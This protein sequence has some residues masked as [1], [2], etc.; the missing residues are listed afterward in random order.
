MLIDGVTLLEGSNI[1]NAV[2][3]N[4]PIFPVGPTHSP[5]LGE[6]FFKTDNLDGLGA[7]GLYVYDGSTWTHIVDGTALADATSVATTINSGTLFPSDHVIVNGE[8]FFL[9]STYND[10]LNSIVYLPGLYV[11]NIAAGI[12]G[13]WEIIPSAVDQMDAS[14]ITSGTMN[15]ARVPDLSWTK[16]TTDKPT[17]I[18]GYG[19]TDAVSSSSLTTH[20]NDETKHL[21][22]AQNALI[23]EIS[24]SATEINYLS[25]TTENIH[26]ALVGKLSLTGG[27]MTGSIIL[28]TNTHISIAD[29]PTIGTHAANKNYVDSYVAGLTWKP[30]VKVATLT[31]IVLSSSQIIDGITLLTNDRVLVKNQTNLTENGIYTVAAGVWSRSLDM[32]ATTPINELN[33]AAVFVEQ[34]STQADTGWTQINQVS[35]LGSDPIAFTQ[36]NGAAGITTGVGLAK[37]GNTL[38]VLLG[39]GITELP[40]GDVGV[41]VLTSGGLFLTID[42]TTSSTLTDAQLSLTKVGTAGIY[43]SVTVDAHGRVTTGTNPTTLAGYSI[44]D[45]QGL[46]AVLTSIT[47]Q[48]SGT[49]LLKLT[50]GTASLDTT[51]YLTAN[52]AITL[53]GDVTGTGN[54]SFA[55]TLA[56]VTQGVGTNFV[57]INVDA[58]GRVIGNTAVAQSDI[59]SLLSTGSITNTM[60]V[61][62]AVANLSG[63][64]T[65][66]ETTASVRTLL[67]ITTLSGSNTG[68]QTITLTGGVTGSGTGSFIATVVTNANLTGDVTSIGN[69]TTLS[70]TTVTGKLLTGYT[71]TAG[72]IAAT[73]S[74]L[75]SINKL[76]GNSVLKA[77]IANPTFTGEVTLPTGSSSVAPIRFIP[78]SILS[79]PSNGSMEYDGNNFYLTLGG[80]RHTVAYTDN[81]PSSVNWS[82]ITGTPTT[83]TGYGIT[84]GVHSNVSITGA[85]HTKI[86]Y[87]AKGLVTGGADLTASDVPALDWGK[88]TSG[89]PTTL[90]GYG[91]TDG[92]SSGVNNVFHLQYGEF[93]SANLITTDITADQIIDV[94][95]ISTFRT[96]KYLIQVTSGTSYQSSELLVIHDNINA[97]LTEYAVI[98]TNN[99]LAT[100]NATV[101]SGNLQLLTTPYNA[102]T[103]FK[104][105]RTAINI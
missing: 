47:G 12:D 68:D 99:L 58:K 83:L 18:S 49:G 57:K 53:T 70:E 13:L 89:K 46:N 11:F 76:N 72:T 84:D 48:S 86:T 39:A 55:T 14:K 40:T 80:V 6:L 20:I 69:A 90:S 5:D 41:D 2:I 17:T 51:N 100:F 32:D 21:T 34:G 9:T 33:S 1:Q 104:V 95:A 79:T 42:G 93:S 87:D 54:G 4:G 31:N 102:L 60:L 28:P 98:V 85:T 22:I 66:N 10:I 27:E 19:I 37:S 35:T 101:I 64:N 71:G 62:T 81:I 59:T 16:I 91:I 30:S 78:G 74:I 105:V 44:S 63:T 92:V 8:A 25:G 56:T 3:V 73:D 24:A 88:I 61:N 45:A 52:Q 96:I 77:P 50:N 94:A 97:T 29:V 75:S 43:R 26:T 7:S 67:G 36:F 82:T 103:T 15:V 65:G 38:S 23:D